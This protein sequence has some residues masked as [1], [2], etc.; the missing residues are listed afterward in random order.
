MHSGELLCPRP[1]CHCSECFPDLVQKSKRGTNVDS[2]TSACFFGG[3]F[4][5]SAKDADLALAVEARAP[6]IALV[7]CQHEAGVDMSH[8]R[9]AQ[10]KF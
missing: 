5:Q 6:G 9:P 1:V 8:C 2:I 4:T 3:R 7:D 10:V